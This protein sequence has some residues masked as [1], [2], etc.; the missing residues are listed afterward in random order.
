MRGFCWITVSSN[1]GFYYPLN[2]FYRHSDLELPIVECVSEVDLPEPYQSLLA[3]ER[4][5][6]PTLADF[7]SE[8]ICLEVLD[9]VCNQEEVLRKVLLVLDGSKKPVAFGAISIR[10]APFNSAAQTRILEGKLPLGTILKLY[11][12]HHYSSPQSFLKVSSDRIINEAFGLVRSGK[13]Y[14]RQN[15]LV[16]PSREILAEI[17]EILPPMTTY[18]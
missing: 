2:E 4:D 11:D 12:I 7:H 3:H 14:G 18:G 17:V 13:L 8:E 1:D 9:S 10:L 15:L 5:M 16:T 6:T